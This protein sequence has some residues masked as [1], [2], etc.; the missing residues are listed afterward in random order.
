[1]RLRGAPL[2][3]RDRAHALPGPQAGGSR[4]AGLLRPLQG[5]GRAAS[6][7]PVAAGAPRS[8]GTLREGAV[9]TTLWMKSTCTTCRD[10]KSKLAELG[11]EAETRDYAKRP[12]EAGELE[13]LLLADPAPMLGTKSPKYRELGLKDRHL[14]KAEA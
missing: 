1:D 4:A 8:L 10:A 11:I 2:P 5:L 12:L 6:H 13:A 14:S 7:R 3:G 9:K